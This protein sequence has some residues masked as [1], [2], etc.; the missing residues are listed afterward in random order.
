MR[1]ALSRQNGRTLLH[2]PRYKTPLERHGDHYPACHRGRHRRGARHPCCIPL[3]PP[4][5]VS[6][7]RAHPSCIHPSN[8]NRIPLL[9]LRHRRRTSLIPIPILAYCLGCL[10]PSLPLC[11]HRH[12]AARTPRG[13]VFLP[14]AQARQWRSEARL[15]ARL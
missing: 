1:C 10:A 9:L 15:L 8:P 14:L 11:R 12:L 13:C 7:Q 4:P 3:P 6:I 5:A 2:W